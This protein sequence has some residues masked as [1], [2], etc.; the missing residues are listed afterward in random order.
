MISRGPFLSWPLCFTAEYV[1]FYVCFRG[2]SCSVAARGV[3]KSSS[4]FEKSGP[5]AIL[6]V[7][8]VSGLVKHYS[9]LKS[10]REEMHPAREA[11]IVK[12]SSLVR[13]SPMEHQET[14][15]NTLRYVEFSQNVLWCKH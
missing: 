11:G 10:K 12:S 6:V 4:N 8:M 2:L 13:K 3:V 9:P 7:S 5:T 15:H 14:S 1:V